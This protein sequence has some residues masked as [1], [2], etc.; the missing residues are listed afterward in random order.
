MNHAADHRAFLER[1][2]FPI[3]R[4]DF[5]PAERALLAKYGRWLE[6]LASGTLLPLTPSQEQFVKVARV[7][8]EP[9]T[10]FEKAWTK[11]MRERAMAPEVIRSFRALSEARSEAAALE[12]EYREAR[13]A[14][15][16]Q[17]REQLEG[18]D[19][20]YAERLRTVSDAAAN[21]EEELRA[22]LLDLKHSVTLAGIRAVYVS[23]RVTYDSKRLEAYAETHPEVREFRKLSNPTVSLRFLDQLNMPEKTVSD[24]PGEGP[25]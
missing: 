15:L 7:Q 22:L 24:R 11:I 2:D 9:G 10:E 3:P 16:A 21:C 23:G 6:A 5:T 8:A 14:I 17:V 19:A 4:G 20:Q 12:A 13:S 18:V 1:R 25:F